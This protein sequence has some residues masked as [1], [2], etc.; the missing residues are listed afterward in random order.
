MTCKLGQFSNNKFY[1]NL[2]MGRFP[3]AALRG[4][5]LSSSLW[6]GD[7]LLM[8][9][10]RKYYNSHHLS[11]TRRRRRQPLITWKHQ[12]SSYPSVQA[13]KRKA[14]RAPGIV[15]PFH[16]SS[17]TGSSVPFKL[18]ACPRDDL[19]LRQLI[20]FQLIFNRT[21]GSLLLPLSRISISSYSLLV[22]AFVLFREHVLL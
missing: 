13:K 21:R 17:F 22:V 19:E 3:N 5:L 20:V 12:P 11:F 2:I 9:R 16:H 15:R 6:I 8:D 18:Y 4:L 1:D 10:T 14:Q 7:L